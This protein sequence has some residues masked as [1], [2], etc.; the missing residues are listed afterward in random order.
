M[1]DLGSLSSTG[2]EPRP[3]SLKFV[4]TKDA[5]PAYRWQFLAIVSSMGDGALDLLEKPISELAAKREAG[6]IKIK[7]EAKG[8]TQ[9]V[10]DATAHC[11]KLLASLPESLDKLQRQVC[12]QLV[13]SLTGR[14]ITLVQ[15]VAI[16]DP[17]AIWQRLKQEFEGT[18]SASVMALYQQAGMIRHVAGT[19]LSNTIA[20]FDDI[21][22]RMSDKKDNPSDG[23]RVGQLMVSLPEQYAP[24]IAA[25][26]AMDKNWT[27]QEAIDRLLAHQEQGAVLSPRRNKV[28]EAYTASSGKSACFNC[29]RSGHFVPDCHSPCTKCPSSVPSHTP[30]DCPRSSGARRRSAS[31]GRKPGPRSKS[32]GMTA[33]TAAAGGD[34]NASSWLFTTETLLHSGNLHNPMNV[35][36]SGCSTHMLSKDQKCVKKYPCKPV[37]VSTASD[38]VLQIRKKGTAQISL[39]DGMGEKHTATL[40]DALISPTL[41]FNLISVSRLDQAGH[42]IKFGNGKAT[43]ER[44]GR[45]VATGVLT[46]AGL[47]SLSPAPTSPT[48]PSSSTHYV[49]DTHATSHVMKHQTARSR[50][51]RV[52]G[53][54]ND[55]LCDGGLTATPSHSISGS[56]DKKSQPFQADVFDAH[57]FDV[58]SSSCD[59]PAGSPHFSSAMNNVGTDVSGALA[60]GASKHVRF[61]FSSPN[62]YASLM[63]N[64]TDNAVRSILRVSRSPVRDEQTD[65]VSRSRV[66]SAQRGG[67]EGQ[68]SSTN[69]HDHSHTHSSP[70]SS[71]NPTS[72]SED[73]PSVI[74][75]L[76]TMRNE[77]RGGRK[78]K[79]RKKNER[80]RN[81]S[82]GTAQFAHAKGPISATWKTLHRRFG[83]P[84]QASMQRMIDRHDVKVIGDRNWKCV[85]CSQGKAHRA[86]FRASAHFTRSSRPGEIWHLDAMGPLRV[87]TTG[88]YL[89]FLFATDDATRMVRG[90][91]MRKKDE[92]VGK[93][94]EL[95]AWSK[96]QTGSP[97]RAIRTDGEWASNEFKELKA[98][99][100]FD[101]LLTTPDTPQSNGV[102][103]RVV[104]II[105][106]KARTLLIDGHLPPSFAGEAYCVATYLHN[107]MPK[108]SDPKSAALSPSERFYK[109]PQTV[110]HLRAFGCLAF[111]RL[112]RSKPGKVLPRAHPGVFVGY[113]IEKRAYRVYVPNL[114]ALFI[115][116][117]VSF[118]ESKRGYDHGSN[119]VSSSTSLYED[120]EY[121]EFSDDFESLPSPMVATP[122]LSTTP[123]SS[124]VAT[125]PEDSKDEMPALEYPTDSDSDD[126]A[127]LRRS[128]RVTKPTLVGLESAANLAFIMAAATVTTKQASA[129]PEWK[130]AMKREIQSLQDLGTFEVV[131]RPGDK[132]VITT[133]WV[134]QEKDAKQ[135]KERYK[136]RLVAQGFKQVYGLDYD[137]TWAPTAR[138]NSIRLI[139]AM[140]VR[141]RSRLRLIDI[142]N[143]FLNAPLNKHRI[144]VEPPAGYAPVGKVWLLRKALY[145]LKQAGK[146]WCEELNRTLSGIGFRRSQ[147]DP[148]VFFMQIERTLVILAV[149]VDDCFIKY[150]TENQLATVMAGLLKQYKVTDMGEVTH[151]LGIDF[152]RTEKTMSMSQ[153]GFTESILERFGFSNAHPAHTPAADGLVSNKATGLEKHQMNAIVGALLWL[154]LNTRP[155]IS[156]AVARLAQFVSAPTPVAYAMAARILRYLRGTLDYGISFSEDARHPI[157]AFADADWAGDADRRSQSGFIFMYA[158]GPIAWSSKKQ[159]CVALSTAEAEIVAASSCVQDALWFTSLL[160]EFGLA[161]PHPITVFEDNEGA[162]A[163]SKT[164]VTGKRTKHIDLRYSFINDAVKKKKVVLKKIDTKKNL[165]DIFTKALARERFVDLSRHFIRGGK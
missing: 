144:Y 143:A 102:A 54:G 101:H 57:H 18:G 20:R 76:S 80:K 120:D 165:S 85:S 63:S 122:P 66:F 108:K 2:Y 69:I 15:S 156:Y 145:G 104:G 148:C 59:E 1:S 45:V 68:A 27:W 121:P 40:S 65:V 31:R 134:Y 56:S 151:A 33:A 115:S 12:R 141:D 149:H 51:S 23:Y 86:P 132:K 43:V 64:E 103:E 81:Q 53:E 49:D 131:S 112:H 24:M 95:L 6:I 150:D 3:S 58:V 111:I 133:R 119:S 83:H 94:R 107:S 11:D 21:F 153:R 71:H 147:A 84:S 125:Q 9:Q 41:H 60:T 140:A 29:G 127:P 28:S 90:F 139:V 123:T 128:T 7:G 100:G 114:Q 8:T 155:D 91:P 75:D 26:T 162:I 42:L 88:G 77:E 124:A 137:E 96:T 113:D 93:L 52:A 129:D 118:D 73:S 79:R 50:R 154:S 159:S 82:T 138:S 146:E 25:M 47:Y 106:E 67:H 152:A 110:D 36:D 78:K 163:L 70:S 22:R 99:C 161:P 13:Q 116:R 61:S 157:Q 126:T 74:E 55:V 164:S 97:I 37:S 30:K 17:R 46:S 109:R 72:V 158:G 89:Y 105:S 5:W 14:A 87:Q 10:A 16:D 98:R 160:S 48:L 32:R 135:G 136:A 39:C 92:Q 19:P 4:G 130:N 44:D 38:V 35:L 117:D 142:K 62:R 34:K